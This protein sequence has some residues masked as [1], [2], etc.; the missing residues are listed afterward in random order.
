MQTLIQVIVL[1]LLQGVAEL[2][3]ISSLG[4]TIII[5]GLLG[6]GDLTTSE[7][8][9]PIVVTLHLGTAVALV[10]FYWRDWL[11]LVR[12][13]FKT[14]MARR[15]DAD[16]Q[17]RAIWLVIV[18]TIPVGILGLALEKTIDKVFFSVQWPVLPAAFLCLNGAI[19]LVGE[20]MRQRAEPAGVDRV[21]Q[22]QAFNTIDD[23]T[24][25]QA[26]FI[27]FAQA[28]AL[29]PGISRSGITMVAALQAKLRHEDALRFTFLLA[30]PV[31]LAASLLEI[32][33]LRHAGTH[34]LMDAGI[35]FVVAFAAA[36]FSVRFLTRYFETGRL[37][38][39]AY[40]S[41]AAGLISFFI[42]APLALGLFQL[43]W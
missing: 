43:P 11:A 22:E 32:P 13:F 29:L 1:A 14:L 42:F 34:I 15:L 18:G 41:L 5:P 37:T 8:F 30:T 7:T 40:Y 33:K 19:L 17:G 6:W 2:F 16:P 38:P 26:F 4:H 3:P 25:K 28:G 9:L 23:L 36:L 21:K 31:I 27:G 20:R 39:F 12:A 35:G 10:V 24:F